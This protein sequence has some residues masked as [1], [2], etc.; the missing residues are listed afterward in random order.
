[1]WSRFRP[2]RVLFLVSVAAFLTACGGDGD[3]ES[4][5]TSEASDATVAATR[6]A[7]TAASTIDPATEALMGRWRTEISPGDNVHLNLRPGAV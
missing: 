6:A 4:D 1:M 2:A 5:P 3:S 7:P